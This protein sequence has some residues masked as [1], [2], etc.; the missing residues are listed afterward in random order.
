MHPDRLRRAIRINI[1]RYNANSI[2]SVRTMN[3]F[4]IA[5]LV[6]SIAIA[7]NAQGQTAADNARQAPTI[8][9]RLGQLE[10]QQQD[11]TNRV[12]M[13]SNKIA[14]LQKQMK[15]AVED[16]S[17]A[18]QDDSLQAQ[19]GSS[20]AENGGAPDHPSTA[21][22][23]RSATETN[24]RQGASY[25]IFYDRLQPEGRWFSD[26]TYGYV[27]QP[28]TAS[29]DQNWRPYADGHWVYTDRGWTWLSN[30]DFG[31]ATY[32][33]GRWAKLNDTGWVWV[34]G[35]TWAPAW[36]S[37]RQSDD[38]MGWAPLP[39]EAESGQDVS[40]ESW[41]DTYYNIGPT[42]YVFVKTTDLA[43]KSYRDLIISPDDNLDII[44][45][46]K[47]V[48]N[49]YYGSAGIVANGPDYSQ[50][51]QRSNVKI[52]RYRLN[53]VQQG[54][55]QAQFSARARGDQLEVV[56]PAPRL[57]RTASVEPKIAGDITKAQVDRGWQNID[58]A[59]ARQL[60]QAWA[61]QAPVPASLPAKPEAPKPLFAR[62]AGQNQDESQQPQTE[63]R[64]RPSAP[65][66]SNQTPNQ[67]TTV[68]PAPSQNENAAQP[69]QQ[70]SNASER[71]G[72]KQS[73]RPETTPPAPNPSP[74]SDEKATRSG[75]QP[76][77]A[78]ENQRNELKQGAR[79]ETTP[80]APNPSPSSDE[81]ATRSG[82]QPPNANENRRQE[83]QGER[84][85]TTPPAVSPSPEEEGPVPQ[86]KREETSPGQNRRQVQ[87]DGRSVESKSKDER[88]ARS[89]EKHETD[90]NLDQ[91]PSGGADGTDEKGGGS[92]K[93]DKAATR[94]LRDSDDTPAH[95]EG[96]RPEVDQNSKKSGSE[97]TERTNSG[98]KKGQIRHQSDNE[99][100]KG[101]KQSDESEKKK[102]GPS[103]Q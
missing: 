39:P 33:Y 14:D 28:N 3:S 81:K 100:S 96:Q 29:A 59:R 60:K 82:E 85:E 49:I 43:N 2:R 93:E 75:E 40:I 15:T 30:E 25:D 32:H 44:S 1:N 21:P 95:G 31:W 45:R 101:N 90:H 73:V 58:E 68:S 42:A 7:I 74:S 12:E 94:Q 78:S 65:Q 16:R 54:N 52:D 80:P 9:D 18:S 86:P 46:T 89:E 48:T 47:N 35:A 63:N 53:F 77:N 70:P 69:G 38:Y 27:W 97:E 10:Q 62:A 6:G 83:K 37:W 99:K 79:P 13:L 24:S 103:E 11:L 22:D 87:G 92:Q 55:P 26:E 36:V 19:A 64:E 23:N 41:A 51:V 17:G 98:D 66:R 5:L 4:T 76:P 20:N 61:R 50:L 56:A 91:V 102:T 71:N 67:E 8:E 57:Q 72:L 84:S 88:P 34:P